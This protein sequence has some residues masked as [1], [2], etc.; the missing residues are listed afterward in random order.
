MCLARQGM[1]TDEVYTAR[2]LNHLFSI[3][4]YATGYFYKY[5]FRPQLHTP[6]RSRF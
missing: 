5:A 3:A 2:I 6:L 1:I 4:I